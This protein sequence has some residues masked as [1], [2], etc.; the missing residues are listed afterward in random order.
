MYLELELLLCVSCPFFLQLGYKDNP[1]H[2]S[3]HGVDVAQTS[4]VLIRQGQLEVTAN[5]CA[6]GFSCVAA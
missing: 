1:Y 2:N 3:W 4:H 6:S 5:A